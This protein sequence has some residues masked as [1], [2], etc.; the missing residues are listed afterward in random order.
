MSD[1]A[2]SYIP[3]SIYTDSGRSSAITMGGPLYT[4]TIG[5]TTPLVLSVYGAVPAGTYPAGT[6]TD[7]ATITI[8]Y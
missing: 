2:S 1:G 8:N 7:A 4:G 3:Y 5:A 6:Y